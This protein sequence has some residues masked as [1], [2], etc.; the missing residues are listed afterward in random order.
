ML[1]AIKDKQG[2]IFQWDQPGSSLGA[3]AVMAEES[4]KSRADADTLVSLTVVKDTN[5]RHLQP[6]QEEDE[7]VRISQIAWNKYPQTK[8]AI[9]QD[10]V[11]GKRRDRRFLVW[12]K[13]CEKLH[14]ETWNETGWAYNNNDITHWALITPP[15]E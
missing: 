1:V 9:T 3:V 4:V 11:S 6:K 10:L 14:F 13:G 12:R 8:P 7:I 15:N 2:K 5:W